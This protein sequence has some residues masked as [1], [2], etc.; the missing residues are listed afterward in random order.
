MAVFD[1][2]EGWYNPHRRHSALDYRAPIDYERTYGGAANQAVRRGR[3]A[4]RWAAEKCGGRRG[5]RR[6]GRGSKTSLRLF[7]PTL[8][9]D[10]R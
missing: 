8:C 10:G 2:I 1:F 6:G 4:H 3:H 5:A 9:S 7:G